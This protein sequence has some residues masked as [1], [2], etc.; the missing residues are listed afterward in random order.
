M[1]IGLFGEC[2]EEKR[3]DTNAIMDNAAAPTPTISNAWS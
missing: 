2:H 1:H 3:P